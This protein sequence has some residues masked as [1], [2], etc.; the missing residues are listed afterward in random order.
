MAALVVTG[1]ALTQFQPFQNQVAY[2]SAAESNLIQASGS[3]DGSRPSRPTVLLTGDS[4][5]LTLGAALGTPSNEQHFGVDLIGASNLGCGVAEGTE[6]EVAGRLI[7][8][9]AACNPTAPL[10]DQWPAL[11]ARAISR[12]RPSIVALLAGRWEVFDRTDGAGEVTNIMHAAYAG[13]VG[14]QLDRFVTEASSGGAEVELLTAPYFDSGP[15][16]D[17]QPAPQ[18]DP[19][20]VDVYNRILS[21]VAAQHPGV[22]RVIDLNA[23]VSPNGT[24]VSHVGSLTVRTPDGI[25]FPFYNFGVPVQDQSVSLRTIQR[26]SDWIGAQLW[27]LIVEPLVEGLPTEPR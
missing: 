10:A 20:R 1:L 3:T 26:F 8:V 21:S 27:P 7:E 18:D 16:P 19:E 2:S 12:D 15:Q 5:A 22:A 13:Y 25:H 9:P 17:G 23:L 6:I 4:T 24:Y 14:S 11:L